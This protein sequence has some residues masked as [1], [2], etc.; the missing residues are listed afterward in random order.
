MTYRPEPRYAHKEVRQTADWL[1]VL[2]FR[3]LDVDSDDHPIFEWPGTGERVKLPGTPRG[4]SW[5]DNVRKE[6]AR[7]AG[8][9]IT[10]KRDATAIKERRQT[11]AEKAKEERER[12][13]SH[14][15]AALAGKALARQNAAARAAI[16]RQVI[17][18]RRE[19]DELARLMSH[20]PGGAR[21]D[22]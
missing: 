2:G 9:D 6:A 8:V 20:K 18:R 19:L 1:K 12:R 17:D 7:I 13:K 16:Q 15:L 10:N 4:H 14:A 21:D 5:L 22:Y 3:F 11:A